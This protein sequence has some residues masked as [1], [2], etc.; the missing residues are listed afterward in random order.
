MANPN[1]AAVVPEERVDLFIEPGTKNDEPNVLISVNGVNY[2]LPR[3]KVSKVP[4]FVAYEFQRA[5]RAKYVQAENA[6]AL[7]PKQAPN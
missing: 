5:R 2:L 1:K 3:G 4:K 6:E 7:K